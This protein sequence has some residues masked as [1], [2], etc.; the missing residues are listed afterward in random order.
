MPASAEKE[1]PAAPA[2]GRPTEHNGVR[3]V[4]EQ[5]RL[6]PLN[7]SPMKISNLKLAD[8]KKAFA[9]R[10][11][12]MTGDT[13]ADV[14]HHRNEDHGSKYG[15]KHLKVQVKIPADPYLGDI[16]LPPRNGNPAPADTMEM[17]MREVLSLMPSIAALGSL[18]EQLE[19]DRDL[20]AA[21]LERRR[22]EDALNA[23]KLT[24]YDSLMAELVERRMTMKGAGSYDDL[25]AEVAELRAWKK[26]VIKRF[27]AIGFQFTEEDSK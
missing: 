5:P 8:G 24:S 18:V 10:D 4:E 25:K 21:E 14:M 26:A 13:L 23:P 3:I 9:C 7:Q 16:V 17:T 2:K 19:T 12:E 22:R 15:K 20:L 27:G 6:S 11:C 1:T